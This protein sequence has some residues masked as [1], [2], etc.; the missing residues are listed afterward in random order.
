MKNKLQI[1][2]K[3]GWVVNFNFNKDSKSFSYDLT[4]KFGI[5]YSI[6]KG[7]TD[8]I[9]Q[10]IE[11]ALVQLL[12]NEADDLKKKAL[13]S[14]YLYQE[15]T[16]LQFNKSSKDLF[17][18]EKDG[19]KILVLGD[20][21][22]K[23]GGW[24][25]VIGVGT[26]LAVIAGGIALTV[27][28]GGA[29]AAPL[30][31]VC[32]AGGTVS[33]GISGTVYSA[34]TEE[35]KINFKDFAKEC[36]V[37][38]VTGAVSA[39]GAAKLAQLGGKIVN[40]GGKTILKKVVEH[41]FTKGVGYATSGATTGALGHSANTATKAVLSKDEK[42]RNKILKEGFTKK[43]MM[44]SMA[45]GAVSGVINFAGSS[46][47][48]TEEITY[49]QAANRIGKAAVVGG[50][51]SGSA[52][53][54]SNKIQDKKWNHGL[55]EAMVIG[56]GIS[57]AMEAGK[58]VDEN[59][60]IRAKKENIEKQK[61]ENAK[62]QEE[63]LLKEKN[64]RRQKAREK[65]ELDRKQKEE[66][67]SQ[68]AKEKPS[69]TKPNRSKNNAFRNKNNDNKQRFFKSRD[70]DKNNKGVSKDQVYH[71]S[72]NDILDFFD[73]LEQL[74]KFLSDMGINNDRDL[75]RIL[76]TNP[77]LAK[78]VQNIRDTFNQLNGNNSENNVPSTNHD[79]QKP[80]NQALLP[81][82]EEIAS[83]HAKAAQ[84]Q[85]N[86]APK[87]ASSQ[88]NEQADASEAFDINQNRMESYIQEQTMSDQYSPEIQSYDI[89]EIDYD[90]ASNREL[91]SNL[92]EHIQEIMEQGQQL[93]QNFDNN[94]NTVSPGF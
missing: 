78:K 58:I 51:A 84:Q 85:I 24:N 73:K 7:F 80:Q 60:K 40:A 15:L 83:F 42:E 54:L 32:T 90:I 61:A 76:D 45:A 72:S 69:Q 35:E 88:R 70:H 48:S 1:E 59:S 13:I 4:D 65:A 11:P 14:E 34:T 2:G 67:E 92:R 33:A 30:W 86:E 89:Q 56:A 29:A 16:K 91:H 20:Y 75:S 38:F 9:I 82:R 62:K 3:E 87:S 23:G 50:V 46:T 37:G 22:L 26:S 68:Q 81:T 41:N 79:P 55:K 63:E 74:R 27:A 77:D 47:P 93:L 94:R 39:G 10:N 21:G 53:V 43:K 57:A 5:N 66:L 49:R 71:K 36:T 17:I 52:T 12:Q 25:Q 44:A 31:A 6:D 18:T 64:I 8:I 19:N 28:T